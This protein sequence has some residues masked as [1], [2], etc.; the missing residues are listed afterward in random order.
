[1]F[2]RNHHRPP[3]RV[4]PHADGCKIVEADPNVQIPWSE[5]QRGHRRATCVCGSQDYYE[6]AGRPARVDP[7]D[8]SRAM[9]LGAC[10]FRETTDRVVLQVVL[11]I[12]DEADPSYSWVTCNACDCAWHVPVYAEEER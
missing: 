1:V 2:R 5:I 12:R 11:K 8:P 9:H 4:F 10:E 3:S 7:L 6:P